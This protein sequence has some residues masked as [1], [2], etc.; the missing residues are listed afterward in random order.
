MG[1][2]RL[3]LQMQ[4]SVD[5]SNFLHWLTGI[6]VVIFSFAYVIKKFLNSWCEYLGIVTDSNF[7]FDDHVLR[8]VKKLSR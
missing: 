1:G 5:K 7:S 3:K 4:I 6:M 2:F 8:V